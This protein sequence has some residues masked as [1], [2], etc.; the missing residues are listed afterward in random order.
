MMNTFGHYE[1]HL[2][3]YL[4]ILRKRRTAILIFFVLCLL[5]A[6]IHTVFETVLYRSTSTILIER[7]NPNVVDFKEVMALDA[8]ATEYYQ[9][10]YQML[11]SHTLVAEL[12]KSQHLEQ[13]PYLQGLEEGG[14]RGFLRKFFSDKK[15]ENFFVKSEP[16]DVFI[17]KMLRVDPVRGSRLVEVS[18]L[19]PDPEKAAKLTNKL[20][21]LYINRNLQE[22]FLLSQQASG[23]IAKQLVELKDKVAEAEKNLQQYKEKTGLVVI[24]SIHEKN[25]FLQEAKLELVKVQAEQSKL[26]KRYL[27]AHPK[28]IH[29]QSQ[30]EG[31]QEQIKKEEERILSLSHDAL[32]YQELE[33]EAESSRQIYKSLL[34]R[35]QETKSEANTQASNV[36]VVDKA[37]IPGRPYKPQPLLNFLMA[38]S[39]G[40]GGGV[41][42]A[43]F[44]EYLDS[45]IKI[46]EDV[47][48]GLGLDLLGIVPEEDSKY[49]QKTK[50]FFNLEDHSA[51]A[52]SIRALRTAILFKMRQFPGAR[53]IMLT[54]PNPEEGKSTI[55]LNLASAFQQN[56][57]KV[58]LIDAD[59]RKPKL[60]RL[61]N[62][63]EE[64][65]ISEALEGTLPLKEVIR[66]NVGN[67]GFDFLSCGT[68]SH[69]PAEIL[70]SKA[71]KELIEKLR[72]TYDI[73]LLDSAPYL[74][75]ADTSVLS[76]FTDAIVIITQYHRT[77][78]SQLRNLKRRF[79]SP[80][81]KEIGV[82]INRLS[83]KI[84]DYY[85]QQYYYY[86]Y[87]DDTS[88]K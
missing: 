33:R 85:Y 86:G 44:L 83:V 43:F 32:E 75:V 58:I 2:R 14:W 63:P 71:M 15:F 8:S 24:P 37:E 50:L 5:F 53:V 54:S 9:T 40:L 4:Y 17:R 88:R 73:I 47:E 64:K 77:D 81:I 55:A 56:H 25:D 51:A 21:E 68:K 10:Q 79:N 70:G 67:L 60:H 18:V 29:I 69:H 59:L 6:G 34:T 20:I 36:I 35:L 74:P 66:S 38:I 12:I 82:V 16:E 19:H 76:D 13:D 23:L 30:I 31:L 11:R 61:L 80:Q 49:F 78:R 26:A 72:E 48:K 62:E 41:F 27:P 39:I 3:D 28:M 45:S 65:G 22:R 46:P 87:G 84:K 1:V 52:E 57:L 7:E 42:L